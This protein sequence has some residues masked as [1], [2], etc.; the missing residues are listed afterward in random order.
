MKKLP[1]IRP[2]CHD[3]EYYINHVY[4]MCDNVK[5]KTKVKPVIRLK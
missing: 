3:R 1:P 4:Q 2:Y 5:A